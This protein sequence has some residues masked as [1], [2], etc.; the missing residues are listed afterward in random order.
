MCVARQ[1][2]LCVC[3]DNV[4]LSHGFR[5][6]SFAANIGLASVDD[7]REVPPIKVPPPILHRYVHT[8]NEG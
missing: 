4:K 5:T 6:L 7:R 3:A 2:C 1:N 8:C